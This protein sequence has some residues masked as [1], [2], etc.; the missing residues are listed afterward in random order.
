MGKA[1]T[2]FT[3]SVID[4]LESAG[5]ITFK[6][7]GG[8]FQESGW[9]DLQIYPP[10]SS[11]GRMMHAEIK[12]DEGRYSAQQ[13]N[14]LRILSNRGI[15]AFGLV[16]GD[17]ID[18]F[19]PDISNVLVDPRIQEHSGAECLRMS[20]PDTWNWDT[21]MT[22]WVGTLNRCFSALGRGDDVWN[23]LRFVGYDEEVFRTWGIV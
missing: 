19:F 3:N 15:C 5:C 18:I 16:E 22:L 4:R 2:K 7:H 13:A 20:L 14:R 10:R 8:F 23:S 6:I 17:Y 11:S 21:L 1:E 9:P 12:V